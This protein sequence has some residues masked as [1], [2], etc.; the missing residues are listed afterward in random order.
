MKQFELELSRTSKE[1]K[2][3]LDEKLINIK[4]EMKA[5]EREWREEIQRENLSEDQ[6]W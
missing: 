2:E 5:H 4:Q 1:V 3:K 6:L